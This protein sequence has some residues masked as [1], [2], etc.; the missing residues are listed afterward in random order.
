MIDQQATIGEL[1][2]RTREDLL[3]LAKGLGVTGYSAMKKQDLI[4]QVLKA[5]TEREGNIFAE[6][7]LETVED[8]YGFLRGEAMLPT[9]NDVYVSQSQ[10][11]RFA[12]RTGALVMGQGRPPEDSE[13]Y[14]GLLRV[15]AANGEDP[16][17]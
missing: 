15:E 12:L 14:Y 6:G 10:V 4:T 13:K 8:G 7:V 2:S 5:R 1:E 3:D 16:E 11:R 17:A 9:I